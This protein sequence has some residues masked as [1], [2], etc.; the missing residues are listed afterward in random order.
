MIY[1]D[2]IAKAARSPTSCWSHLK[3]AGSF[4]TRTKS[5]STPRLLV[6]SVWA[7]GL[8]VCG[9]PGVTTAASAVGSSAG[10]RSA[11]TWCASPAGRQDAYREL[12]TAPMPHAPAVGHIDVL[13]MAELAP[14]VTS[15]LHSSW[16]TT[17]FRV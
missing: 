5:T 13:N 2:D 3:T 9:W 7:A 16:A 17:E 15:F 11:K 8:A 12:S 10:L 4:P 14:I 6:V 1:S